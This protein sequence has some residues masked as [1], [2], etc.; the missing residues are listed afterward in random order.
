MF[1]RDAKPGMFVRVLLFGVPGGTVYKI[2]Q[3]N[4][5]PDRV[6]AY[7]SVGTT[8]QLYPLNKCEVV[9]GYYAY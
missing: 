2:A 9:D 4:T 3:S 6:R 5:R 1:V 8:V 7:T